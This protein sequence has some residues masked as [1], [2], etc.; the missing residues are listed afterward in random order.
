M[1]LIK[2]VQELSEENAEL[3]SRLDR[4]ETLLSAQGKAQPNT[5]VQKG[6]GIYARLEQNV[7]NPFTSETVIRYSLPAKTANAY[8]NFFGETGILVKSVKLAVQENGSINIKS[9]E[10][11]K[12]IIQY[13][14]I[15]NGKIVTTK[16][17]IH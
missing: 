12:G 4:I 1:P 14:L 3:K 6:S 15:V 10:L 8:I 11:P 17:M 13:A 5:D 7:P 16:E 2:A 9:A